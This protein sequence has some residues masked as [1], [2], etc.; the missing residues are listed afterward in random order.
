M[1]IWLFSQCFWHG[2][3]LK[4]QHDYKLVGGAGGK[5]SYSFKH[6]SHLGPFFPK[7]K[8][9]LFRIETLRAHI[10]KVTHIILTVALLS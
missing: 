7:T 3:C 9:Y 5:L 8:K 4:R 2:L 6:A 10:I 1:Q